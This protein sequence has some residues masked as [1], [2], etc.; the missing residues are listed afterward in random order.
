MLKKCSIYGY[1]LHI[2]V[3]FHFYILRLTINHAELKN[4]Y[5]ITFNEVSISKM[6]FKTVNTV[7]CKLN[8]FINECIILVD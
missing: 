8:L 1:Y 6:S 4:N 5:V 2:L 7:N 3:I